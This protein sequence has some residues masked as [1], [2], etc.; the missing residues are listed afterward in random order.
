LTFLDERGLKDITPSLSGTND[1]ECANMEGI[2]KEP[3]HTGPSED[4]TSGEARKPVPSR[5][6]LEPAPTPLGEAAD[7]VAQEKVPHRRGALSGWSPPRGKRGR[8]TDPDGHTH[9]PPETPDL[10]SQITIPPSTSFRDKLVSLRTKLIAPYLILSLATAMVGI[11]VVTRLVTSSIRERFANQV[12]EASRV[13]AESIVR[14]EEFHLE[15]LRA[16]AFTQGVSTAVRA[17][18]SDYLLEALSPMVLNAGV[19]SLSVA[20]AEGVEILSIKLDFSSGEYQVFRGADL[21]G[22]ELMHKIIE[23]ESDLLGDKYA[24]IV[25]SS[26]GPY[27]VTTAPVVDQEHGRVG[28]IMLGTHLEHFLFH[29]KPEVL[30]DLVTLDQSGNLLTTTLAPPEHGYQVIELSAGDVSNLNP[31]IHRE[32]SLYEREFRL[33]Y[34]PLIVRQQTLGVLGVALPSN[35]IVSVESTSR[36]LL[37]VIFSLGSMGIIISGYLLARSIARPIT[38]LRNVSLAVASGDLDQRTGLK[39]RDEIGQLAE[40]FD[41]MTFRLSKRTRQAQQLNTK[42]QK[43][44]HELTE[45]NTRLQLAQQQVV[46]SE[47]LASVGQLTAGIVHDIRNP[48]AVIKGMAEELVTMVEED[49]EFIHDLTII[50]DNASRANQIVG[51]LLKFARQSEPEKRTQNLSATALNALR[52]TQYLIRK[53]KVTVETNLGDVELIA[54]YDAQQLEQVFVNLI[55]NAVQAMLDGGTLKLHA[56]QTPGWVMVS[57]VDTGSGIAEENIG[58]IF[59]PFFTTKP[60]VEGTGLGLSVCYGLI[61]EH[62]GKLEVQSSPG[63]GTVFRVKLPQAR[64]PGEALDPSPGQMDEPGG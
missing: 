11:L 6:T 16:M 15:H 35:F 1:D 64:T 18:D 13:A 3:H 51:D 57:I 56:M 28:A 49:P 26:E 25:N 23:G 7:R 9:S 53:A 32:V 62:Q 5:N 55:Q 42:L 36:N 24:G 2:D 19:D 50:R 21:G 31:A 12:L 37:T 20:D 63:Q 40:I 27:L 38:R 48:L 44:A 61:S 43:R 22:L 17:S 30:A 10:Y 58:R 47:K 39:G 52:L 14:Q 8:A 59:D 4:P 34:S 46:Q 33:Y 54:T 29:I 60:A 41:L 45:L